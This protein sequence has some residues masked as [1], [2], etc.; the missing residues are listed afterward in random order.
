MRVELPRVDDLIS[1]LWNE[2]DRAGLAARFLEGVNRMLAGHGSAWEL[3]G[4]GRL[5]RVLPLP[6]QQQVEA[7]IAE[8]QD[9][10]QRIFC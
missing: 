2:Y 10:R 1:R 5:N 9:T 4:D 3:G 8:L 7:A 6:A